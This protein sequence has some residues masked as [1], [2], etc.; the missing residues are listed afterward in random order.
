[1]KEIDILKQRK[2]WSLA[3]NEKLINFL[4]E[5]FKK[6]TLQLIIL[7]QLNIKKI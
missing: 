7:Y 4:Q 1:M 6:L 5:K 2:E 3:Q